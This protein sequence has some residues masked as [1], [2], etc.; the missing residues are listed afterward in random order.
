MLQPRRMGWIFLIL[1]L[2]PVRAA[3]ALPE[4]DDAG[5]IARS[6]LADDSYQ[7]NL[8]KA[9]ELKIPDIGFAR[10]LLRLLMWLGIGIALALIVVWLVDQYRVR[11]RYSGNAAV[12]PGRS[13][14]TLREDPSPEE[15]EDHA[16]AGRF[17]EAVH[18][19]LLLAVGHLAA[20]R[21]Q[22][23]SASDTGRELLRLL[24]RTREER[25]LLKRLVSAVELS[26]FGGRIVTE[27]MYRK[28]LAAYR[29]MAS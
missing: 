14:D 19:L 6:I 12:E 5:E 28:C 17:N 18:L 7:K 23:L 9:K 24:P 11:R 8:V 3:T 25:T 4:P 27:E 13:S 15:V 26:L 2:I 16:A 1:L 10:I 21:N 20:A 29:S 22:V